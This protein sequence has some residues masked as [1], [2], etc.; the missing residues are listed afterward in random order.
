MTE[1]RVVPLEWIVANPKN[2]NGHPPEQI[3]SLKASLERFRQVRPYVVKQIDERQF[4]LAAGEGT[5]TA[6]REL[7]QANPGKNADLAQ[8]RIVVVPSHWTDG[9]VRAYMI[10]DN[11]TAKKAEP[12]DTLLAELLQEQQNAGYD[13]AALGSDEES[14]R[15]ML[16][17]LGDGYLD[18]SEQGDDE[19][20][21]DDVLDEEQTRVKPGDVW[22]LGRHII[23]CID[24][25]DV[26][27]VK[28]LIGDRRIS[29]IFADPPYGISIVTANVSVGG[30]EAYDIPFGGVK[31]KTR[32]DVGGGASHIRKTGKSYLEEWQE[33]KNGTASKG[34]GS[35]GGAKPFGSRAVRGS[36]G[37]AN[38]VDVG[39]YAPIVGDDSIETAVV[40]SQMCLE[41]FPKATQIWWGANYYAHTLP[42]SSCWIVWD[43]ENTGNFAD[44]ELAWCSDKSAVRIF[45]HMWNGMLKDSEH[46]QRR[47]H[48][49][50][51]PV[52][53]AEFCYERYGKENDVIFD[54]FLGSG[55]TVIAAERLEG[56]RSIIGCELS[57]D[58]INV[59]ISRWEAETGQTATLLERSEEVAHA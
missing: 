46:G 45:K 20:E 52:K 18:G 23:A 32:G 22:Q 10:A 33:K 28:R 1:Y 29:F 12:D 39:K 34:F 30:G 2:Y 55:I 50:Q 48:P 15:Q 58:Y 21:F 7:V 27:A 13:L 6:A 26:E 44:A 31:N 5:V 57:A 49:S 47:V 24:S 37:A 53:L 3:A 59:V 42:P 54:P 43:K 40:S 56:S 4:M 16:E 11:E 9:D 17:A 35:I 51:K 38:V 8:A 14:L 19:D 36:D 41:F 25:C